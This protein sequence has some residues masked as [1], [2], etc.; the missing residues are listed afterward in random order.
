MLSGHE[1]YNVLPILFMPNEVANK[2]GDLLFIFLSSHTNV[3]IRLLSSNVSSQRSSPKRRNESQ[4]FFNIYI[5]YH[6]IV[7]TMAKSRTNT[8]TI[9]SDRFKESTEDGFTVTS[10]TS[11][12]TSTRDEGGSDEGS[13]VVKEEEQEQYQLNM[14]H[15]RNSMSGRC[16]MDESGHSQRRPMRRREQRRGSLNMISMNQHDMDD[17]QLCAALSGEEYELEKMTKSSRIQSKSQIRNSKAVCCSTNK[18]HN[19]STY[20]QQEQQEQEQQEQ[21]SGG[22][23][24]ATTTTTDREAVRMQRANEKIQ[25]MFLEQRKKEQ[26]AR[27]DAAKER[28]RKNKEI[29]QAEDKKARKAKKAAAAAKKAASAVAAAEVAVNRKENDCDSD[30]D[31]EEEQRPKLSEAQRRQ[32]AYQWYMRCGMPRKDDFRRRVL[33]MEGACDI[34]PDDVDLL[35]WIH[36]GARVNIKQMLLVETDRNAE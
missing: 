26:A 16:C 6:P 14:A 4:L 27:L 33:R 34:Q 25:L 22:A 11:E 17:E 35:P 32:I 28:I 2:T 1:T 36:G 30:D 15:R 29:Q 18:N 19:N 20:D 21:Q 5:I 7:A 9:T 24:G 10:D 8:T 13:I 12:S 23:G 3:A 31:D